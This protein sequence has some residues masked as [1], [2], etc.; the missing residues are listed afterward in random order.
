MYVNYIRKKL[1]T[2]LHN[3]NFG[4]GHDYSIFNTALI[5]LDFIPILLLGSSLLMSIFYLIETFTPWIPTISMYDF[6]LVPSLKKEVETVN[7]GS[8]EQ[9]SG[10]QIKESIKSKQYHAINTISCFAVILYIGTIISLGF[11]YPQLHKAFS[12][13]EWRFKC[14]HGMYNALE[15]YE[16]LKCIGNMSPI[17]AH[18]IENIIFHIFQHICSM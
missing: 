16:Y 10:N 15:T 7:M 5:S 8:S 11:I 2:L 6:L 14:D 1:A 4:R 13:Y 18:D 17:I 9:I 12:L 3:C